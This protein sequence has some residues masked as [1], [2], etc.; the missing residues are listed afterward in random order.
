M[1]RHDPKARE[2]RFQR[3]LSA[4]QHL[5]ELDVGEDDDGRRLDAYL[6][7]R[8]SWRSRDQIRQCIQDGDVSV[9]PA[10]DQKGALLP[11]LR[12]SFRLRTGQRVSVRLRPSAVG[13]EEQGLEA[14]RSGT[15][16]DD[17]VPEIG[18]EVLHDDAALLA[19]AKPAATS[20]YPSRRHAGRSLIELVHARHARRSDPGPPPSPC[21]RLDRDT[22]GVVVFARSL[23]ARAFV[24]EQFERRTVG[25]TYLALVR[26]TPISD[27]GVIDAPLGP[28]P[29]S[30]VQLKQ[31]VRTDEGGKPART[32]WRVLRRARE[33][34]L[35]EL[36]PETGRQHQLRVHLAELGHPIL[37]DVLYL[38][39]DEMFL[40]SLEEPLNAS[41]FARLGRET[42]ALHAWR[43]S[44]VHPSGGEAIEI[45][46]SPPAD[47]MP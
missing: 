43:L 11:R 17:E 25:K 15:A 38:G 32:A 42:L 16:A 5:Y 40:R 20:L 29:A 10:K 21:H 26:G 24:G 27:D 3:D 30:A 41:D 6:T 4:D 31:G 12:P 8:L 46:A 23:A 39:G 1:P 13:V 35:L 37:G 33:H 44:L 34:A 28:H 45:E 47:L 19:V 18:V 22:T 7:S 36:R 14:L 9:Q 2:R